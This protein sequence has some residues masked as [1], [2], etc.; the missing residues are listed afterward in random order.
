MA[1]ASFCE[2]ESAEEAMRRDCSDGDGCY[3]QAQ[4]LATSFFDAQRPAYHAQTGKEK[5][6]PETL[7]AWAAKAVLQFEKGCDLG[8]GRCCAMLGSDFV[9]GG[10]AGVDLPRAAR[11]FDKGCALKDVGA[12]A[13]LARLYRDGDGVPKNRALQVKYRKLACDFADRLEK[14]SFCSDRD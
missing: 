3:T 7:A 2:P 12:C 8:G 5:P 9:T 10:L 14:E 13:E 4:L 11:L 1:K 6:G